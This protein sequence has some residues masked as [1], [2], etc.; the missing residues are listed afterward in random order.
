MNLKH[1]LLDLKVPCIKEKLEGENSVLENEP[2]AL[3]AEKDELMAF[4]H[5]GFFQPMDTYREFTLLNDLWDMGNAPWKV[6]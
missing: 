1:H 5:E 2:M 3:L 6:W 4:N